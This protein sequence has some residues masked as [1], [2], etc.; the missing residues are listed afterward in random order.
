MH[1]KGS[2]ERLT[3]MMTSSQ[4]AKTSLPMQLTTTAMRTMIVT[5][6]TTMMSIAGLGAG[7]VSP[8]ASRTENLKKAVT[9]GVNQRF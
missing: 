3:M 9:G 2:I 8:K 5:V 4:C 6:L 7:S 1:L